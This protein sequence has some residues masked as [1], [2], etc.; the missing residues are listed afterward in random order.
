MPRAPIRTLPRTE[1]LLAGPFVGMRDAP[2]PTTGAATLALLAQNLTRTPGPANAGLTSRPGFS[3]MDAPT[4]LLAEDGTPLLAEDG[5]PLYTGTSITTGANQAI[6]T[7][8]KATGVRETTAIVGGKVYGYDWTTALWTEVVTAANLASVSITLSSTS[9]VA[10]VPFADGLVVSDGVNVPFWWDGTSG[11]GGLVKLT[12]CPVLYGP[13]TVYYAKLMGIKNS[14]RKTLVWSEEGAPNVGY[15]AGGYNNAWDNPGGLADPLTSVVGTNEA[16]YVFRERSSVAITGAVSTDFATAGTRSNLSEDV[17]TL[18]PWASYAATDGVLIVDADA[19]PWLMR[20]GQPTPRPLWTDCRQTVRGTPRA[21]LHQIETV[22]DDATYTYLIGF[23]E[24]GAT[25]ITQWLAF[26]QDD[27]QFVGVWAW[28]EPAG[29]AG[30]VV[31]GQGVARWAHAGVDD[32]AFY[33]HGDLEN[34]P[35]DDALGSG[36]QYITQAV[37]SSAL[38]YDLDRELHVSELEAALTGDVSRI[39]V[40][41]ETPRGQSV[42]LSVSLSSGSGG[43]WD[44]DDWDAVNWA[45]TTRDKRC[46]VGVAGRGRWVRVRVAH[47]EPGEPFG[48]T[49]LRVTAF[50]NQGNPR[51]P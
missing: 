45:S 51:V 43:T 23:P 34:G 18:S 1:V 26:A 28:G 35:W 37:V 27:W 16:L 14:D 40:S 44:V 8:T 15:E 50:A 48:V 33:V 38:G 17:G 42:P 41:Y 20:Y 47:S 4:V 2:E 36:T 46:R 19:Q 49:V 11:A 25:A 24:V 7:W 22:Q 6:R 5:T 32:G 29:R 39:A 10:L 13:P 9:R 12:N 21:V 3:G 30:P 31:D